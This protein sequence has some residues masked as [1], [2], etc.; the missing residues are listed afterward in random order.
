VHLRTHAISPL[1]AYS[2]EKDLQ[3]GFTWEETE[4]AAFDACKSG[5]RVWPDAF[6]L[7]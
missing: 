3:L 2:V 1:F 7:Q 4:A 6:T 5:L